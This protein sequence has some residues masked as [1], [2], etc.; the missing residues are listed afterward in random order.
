MSNIYNHKL[1]KRETLERKLEITVNLKSLC[2]LWQKRKL[3][4]KPGPTASS[5][6]SSPAPQS[7]TWRDREGR[8]EISRRTK[9]S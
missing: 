2:W 1:T 7:C 4:G 3:K 8:E 5:N 6:I 9:K